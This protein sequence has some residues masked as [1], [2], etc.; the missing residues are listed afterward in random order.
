MHSF[1]ARSIS[2]GADGEWSEYRH[3]DISQKIVLTA[4]QAILIL[5]LGL[6]CAVLAIF[7]YLCIVRVY[8]AR[9]RSAA[10]PADHPD[11]ELIDF[12]ADPN[13]AQLTDDQVEVPRPF[14]FS[15][16]QDIDDVELLEDADDINLI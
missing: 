10:H 9:K 12:N 3:I 5:L 8:I 16:S 2:L 7:G 6:L 13:A 14:V 11:L 1:R 15:I 4:G